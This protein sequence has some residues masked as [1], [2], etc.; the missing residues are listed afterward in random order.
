MK[1]FEGRKRRKMNEKT[2]NDAKILEISVEMR[3]LMDFDLENRFR[4]S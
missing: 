2:G 4:N 1:N 3:F